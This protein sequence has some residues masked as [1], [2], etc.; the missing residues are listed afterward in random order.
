M[1]CCFRNLGQD[2]AE[3]QVMETLTHTLWDSGPDCRE[4]LVPKVSMQYMRK[5]KDQL[6]C[7]SESELVL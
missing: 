7:M 1:S 2:S 6:I 5:D 3:T 4:Q